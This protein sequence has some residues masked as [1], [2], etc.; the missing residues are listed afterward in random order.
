MTD[1][2]P[3][4]PPADAC[5]HVPAPTARRPPPPGGGGIAHAA[6]GAEPFDVVSL[7]NVLDRCDK[8]KTLLREIRPLL[9]R[10]GGQL[11]VAVVL[12][13]C[14]F[15]EDGSG[16]RPPAERL[17]VTSRRWEK[18]VNELVVNVFAPSGYDVVRLSRVPYYSQIYSVVEDPAFTTLDVSRSSAWPNA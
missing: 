12:P 4:P 17:A 14:P 13:F 15:V 9:R 1:P 6:V 16:Q 5:A 10:P 11:L 18:A 3:P 7:L 2:E 8:P